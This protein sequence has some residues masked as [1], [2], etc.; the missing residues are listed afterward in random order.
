MFNF[1]RK[2]LS[3]MVRGYDD[4]P[5]AKR[6]RMDG[7][8]FS[9]PAETPP[10]WR[11]PDDESDQDTPCVEAKNE[12]KL[13]QLAVNTNTTGDS[14]DE[15]ETPSMSRRSSR[16]TRSS[17]TGNTDASGDEN[18]PHQPV[19]VRKGS[20]AKKQEPTVETKE[21]EKASVLE[22]VAKPVKVAKIGKKV[23]GSKP[24]VEETAKA[25]DGVEEAKRSAEE[26]EQPT[27]EEIMG[28][29]FEEEELSEEEMKALT[30][31][32]DSEMLEWAKK[33][34]DTAM[35]TER[36]V[37]QHVAQLET[38]SRTVARSIRKRS[39]VEAN[40]GSPLGMQSTEA[41]SAKKGAA[42]KTTSRAKQAPAT[43]KKAPKASKASKEAVAPTPLRRSS[44]LACA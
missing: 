13:Q 39:R 26:A 33:M 4:T 14:D 16:R 34:E 44:R 42:K 36:E 15:T 3:P 9:P 10:G 37:V 27:A 25:E 32:A 31:A 41:L 22:V 1:F 18:K 23:K 35:E 17:A 24:V 11:D 30:A 19:S 6:R 43:E 28:V 21:T 12:G 2:I 8:T 29:E 7:E 38:A 40:V 20:K 5:D